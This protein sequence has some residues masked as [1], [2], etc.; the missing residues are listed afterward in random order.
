MSAAS[1]SAIAPTATPIPIDIWVTMLKKVVAELQRRFW[2]IRKRESR[3]TGELH[4]A[5]QT[6]QE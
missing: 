4:G 1:R 3:Q 5:R 2:N 6:I